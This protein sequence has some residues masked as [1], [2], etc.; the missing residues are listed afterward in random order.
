MTEPKQPPDKVTKWLVPVGRSPWAIAAGY[1]GLCSLIIYPAPVALVLGLLA[2]RD[3][4]RHPELG[5]KGR[6]LFGTAMGLLG[7]A[8]LVYMYLSR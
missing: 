5:G 1:A 7:T 4:K 3:L 2:W 8:L 6:A